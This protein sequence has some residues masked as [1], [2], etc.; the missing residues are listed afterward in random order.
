MQIVTQYYIALV[1]QFN[2]N[3]SMGFRYSELLPADTP[4][5]LVGSA[6]D[7]SSNEP[8]SYSVMSEWSFDSSAILRLQFNHETPQANTVDNQ[9]IF[10]YIM[11]LGEGSHDGHDH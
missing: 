10:Q 4:S 8:E 1:N 9:F 5:G 6:L 2:D 11:Y 3:L 7:A